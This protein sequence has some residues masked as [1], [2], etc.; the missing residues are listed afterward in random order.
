MY[1]VSSI[2][3]DSLLK[4]FPSWINDENLQLVHGWALPLWNI[5]VCQW[6]W[7]NSQLNRNIK[8]MFQTTNQLGSAWWNTF[9][10]FFSGY[11]LVNIGIGWMVLYPIMDDHLYQPISW[12]FTN[13]PMNA[14]LWIYQCWFYT[15]GDDSDILITSNY[16]L[17]NVNKQLWNDTACYSMGKLTITMVM[18]HI[19]Y[20]S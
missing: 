4:R 1:T 15:W 12:G 8:S 3:F 13:N 10:L 19:Q 9:L 7:W 20:L 5:W 17:V 16:H 11:P 2:I 6:G 14:S 18:F